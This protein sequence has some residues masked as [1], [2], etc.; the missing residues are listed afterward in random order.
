MTLDD[1][2]VTVVFELYDYRSDF[3]RRSD[4]LICSLNYTATMSG[5]SQQTCYSS[6]HLC[7]SYVN[8]TTILNLSG[9]STAEPT[10]FMTTNIAASTSTSSTTTTTTTTLNSTS[11]NDN[12]STT[13]IS[14]MINN[15]IKENNV[16][17]KNSDIR[18]IVIIIGC[19]VLLLIII[20]IIYGGYKF[21]EHKQENDD[22]KHSKT[23]AFIVENTNTNSI[24]DGESINSNVAPKKQIQDI[25][26]NNNNEIKSPR[27]NNKKLEIIITNV[28]QHEN[29]GNG[30]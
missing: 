21:Y 14:T 23:A 29:E 26:N 28:D 11:N 13:L 17:S 24:T 10:T 22:E 2:P 16:N 6:L 25:N 18:L 27:G 19:F 5:D 3:I 4:E 9:V 30:N 8:I 12:N 15:A 20:L 7:T 1:Y